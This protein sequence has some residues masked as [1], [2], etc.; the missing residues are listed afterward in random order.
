M[1]L[2]I[3]QLR[4]GW[5]SAS[6]VTFAAAAV[7]LSSAVHA[8]VIYGSPAYDR[9]TGTGFQNANVTVAP[10]STAGDGVGVGYASKYTGGTAVGN[11]AVRWDKTGVAT[12]LGTLGTDGSGVTTSQAFAVNTAGTAVG[13]ASKFV[14]GTSVGRRAVRWDA[15]GIAA[16]ELD[17]LGTD[18]AGNTGSV[19]YAVNADGTAVGTAIEYTGGTSVGVRAVRWAATG[20]AATE[21][22]TLGTDSIGRTTA[23]AYA[24]NSGGTAVGYSDKYVA[25]TNVGQR[26]VRWNSAGTVATELDTLGTD[27]AGKTDSTAYAV[28]TDGTVV[29][30]AN[31]YAGGTFIGERAV[32]WTAAGHDAT[33]LDALDTDGTGNTT[34]VAQAIN[35]AGTAVGYASKYTAGT[36]VGLRAIR[37][38]AAGTAATELGNLGTTANGPG[39]TTDSQA[40][41][42]NTAGIAVGYAKKYTAGAFVGQRAVAWGL[43][44][45]AIDLNTLLSPTDASFWTLTAASGISETGWVTGVGSYDSDGAAGPLASYTRAFLIQVPEPTSLVTLV[46]CGTILL[47]RGRRA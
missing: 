9:V 8:A 16:T 2:S 18:N 22:G 23:R 17:A 10:G 1:L 27:S 6:A 46:T 20:V 13:F 11:R 19:A 41:A 45:G 37:W 12:E 32:R 43:D 14:A 36:F 40:S 33:E 3:C 38:D 35:T 34:S 25:G 44:G 30:S 28:N 7:C 26:A 4:S 24:V 39:S 21:L 29:G 31:K 15:A 42:V 5:W 47:L